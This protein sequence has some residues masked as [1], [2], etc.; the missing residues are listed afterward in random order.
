MLREKFTIAVR[1]RYKL[2]DIPWIW[3]ILI[4]H[5]RLYVKENYDYSVKKMESGRIK[6]SW[7]GIQ[8][9]S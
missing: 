5:F 7:S 8:F 1:V 4:C 3:R 9:F 6:T 2:E